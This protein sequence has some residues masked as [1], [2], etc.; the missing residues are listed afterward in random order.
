MTGLALEL[1]VGGRFTAIG[2]AKQN[3]VARLDTV[4]DRGQVG[5]QNS[6]GCRLK[7]ACPPV[8]HQ[9]LILRKWSAESRTHALDCNWANGKHKLDYV[10]VDRKTLPAGQPRCS[11]CGGG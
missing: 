4:A 2:G 9:V 10:I 7:S 8:K 5:M 6:Q 3:Y 11:R 1:F